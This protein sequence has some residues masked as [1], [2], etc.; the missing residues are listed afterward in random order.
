MCA[1]NFAQ[2]PIRM[3]LQYF[4][5]KITIHVCPHDWLV[6]W[7]WLINA[8]EQLTMSAHH[9][10]QAQDI[11]CGTARASANDAACCTIHVELTL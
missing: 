2:I 4:H 9:D 6:G 8:S 3:L 7:I 1:N 5:F 10:P 11:R